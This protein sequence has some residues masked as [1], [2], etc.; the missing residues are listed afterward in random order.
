MIGWNVFMSLAV[1][2]AALWVRFNAALPLPIVVELLMSY[3][4]LAFIYAATIALSGFFRVVLTPVAP[5]GTSS[6]EL[7]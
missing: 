3:A 2:C 5:N 7:P 6:V 4:S 1:F